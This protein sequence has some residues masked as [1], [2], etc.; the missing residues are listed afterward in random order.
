M[1]DLFCMGKKQ[2]EKKSHAEVQVIMLVFLKT[3]TLS[4][5][6]Q[7]KHHLHAGERPKPREKC[8]IFRDICGQG[9]SH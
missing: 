4:T 6:L 7:E 8:Y 3:L 9:L 1:L 2:K 5:P